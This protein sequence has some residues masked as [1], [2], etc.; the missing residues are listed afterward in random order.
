MA[1]QAEEGMALDVRQTAQ[2]VARAI[3]CVHHTHIKDTITLNIM[4]WHWQ[5]VV[6][7]NSAEAWKNMSGV[8]TGS[9]NRECWWLNMVNSIILLVSKLS[10]HTLGLVRS[11]LPS[12]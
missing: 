5:S 1:A 11:I 6:Q 3:L 10:N 12:S 4:H 7:G 8:H 9:V 2:V